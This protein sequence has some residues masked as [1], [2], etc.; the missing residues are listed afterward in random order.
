M[1]PD[2]WE[3]AK[4]G[5]VR[6]QKHLLKTIKRRR[7]LSHA[8]QEHQSLATYVGVGQFGP[9][10]EVDGL[11]RNKNVLME[12]LLK[13][14]Q[15]QQN[16]RA[17][18]RAMEERLQG[19]EQRQQQMMTFLA[20]AMQHPIFLQ[21]L[22]QQR[23]KSKELEEAVSK[24]R[25][26][27]IDRTPDP[28]DAKPSGSR[29]FN[30]DSQGSYKTFSYQVPGLESRALG[31]EGTVNTSDHGKQEELDVELS[32]E[33]WEELISEGISEENTQTDFGGRSE[34]VVDM[35]TERLEYLSSASAELME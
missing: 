6:G 27:A 1:D 12:E 24:K 5:F 4:E 33:F 35:L 23:G 28:S 17:H 20:R 18:L 15:E 10:G 26:Q 2:R 31:M 7:P 8:N 14:R 16:T 11:K 13:L 32:D 25:R 19:T 30:M 29:G 22:V 3:F 21:Q 34:E 9:D